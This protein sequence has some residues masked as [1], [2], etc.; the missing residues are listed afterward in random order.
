MHEAYRRQKPWP[1][2]EG[3]GAGSVMVPLSLLTELL[4]CLLPVRA[5][6]KKLLESGMSEGP[7]LTSGS[8]TPRPKKGR[9]CPAERNAD[10]PSPGR[11]NA[12]GKL[13]GAKAPALL[14]LPEVPLTGQPGKKSTDQE[15][16]GRGSS[17][18]S[19]KLPE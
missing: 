19:L 5:R 9:D 14:R 13:E 4:S 17:P 18:S 12:V 10:T 11:S 15:P 16:G 6:Q 1:P 7:I 2:P 8:H 3:L